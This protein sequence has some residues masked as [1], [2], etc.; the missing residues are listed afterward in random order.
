MAIGKGGGGGVMGDA[1]CLRHVPYP[2]VSY[3]SSWRQNSK[4]Y[5]S[6]SSRKGKN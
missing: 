5:G 3:V 4:R 1:D 2:Q 6:G